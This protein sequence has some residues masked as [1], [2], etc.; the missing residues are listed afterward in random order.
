[1]RHSLTTPGNLQQ[2]QRHIPRWLPRQPWHRL[3]TRSAPE[4]VGNS[5]G[6]W[7]LIPRVGGGLGGRNR[8]FAENS[9]ANLFPSDN[10][11]PSSAAPIPVHGGRKGKKGDAA[12]FT[13]GRT[14]TSFP[15]PIQARLKSPA[16]CRN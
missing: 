2:R 6:A 9:S 14:E 1:M 12:H 8:F 15:R 3:A 5:G 16:V 10:W 7:Q 4:A 13:I 11:F